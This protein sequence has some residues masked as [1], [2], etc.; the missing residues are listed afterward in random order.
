MKIVDA[1]PNVKFNREEDGT[2]TFTAMKGKNISAKDK[3][4][5]K[6][7]L[8]NLQQHFDDYVSMKTYTSLQEN[9]EKEKGDGKKHGA[10][11]I[12]DI[13]DQEVHD[14]VARINSGDTEYKD[15]KYGTK[16]NNPFAKPTEETSILQEKLKSNGTKPGS[17]LT[18]GRTNKQK[19]ED[20]EDASNRQ[21]EAKKKLYRN[22]KSASVIDDDRSS[23]EYRKNA[24]EYEKKTHRPGGN[25][26]RTT[27]SNNTTK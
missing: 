26:S 22:T 6:S 18:Q 9:P 11:S 5:A 15:R 19:S 8:S 12:I 16:M 13:A 14:N 24:D 10:T 27:S 4:N 23:E 21:H 7:S 17:R 1:N 25:T 2:F 3:A 20:A